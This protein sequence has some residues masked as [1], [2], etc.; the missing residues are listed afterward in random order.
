MEAVSGF[1]ANY[2]LRERWRHVPT[3]ANGQLAI[4]CFMWNEER[5]QFLPAAIDVLELRADKVRSVTAF[6][7]P[8]LFERFGEAAGVMT[9]EVF[10]RFG[11]P[12]ELPA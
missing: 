7:A 10:R 3:R 4:G 5:E 1:L 11:L 12:D 9:P 6:L 2:P 8:W